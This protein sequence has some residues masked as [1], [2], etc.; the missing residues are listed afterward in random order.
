[1]NTNCYNN[2]KKSGDIVNCLHPSYNGVKMEVV[3]CLGPLVWVKR[4]DGILFGLDKN[5]NSTTRN[6]NKEELFHE[7]WFNIINRK[8]DTEKNR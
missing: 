5:F 7:T 2:K 3:E 6:N 1:M 8:W 4:F